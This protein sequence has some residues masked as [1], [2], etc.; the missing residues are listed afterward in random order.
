MNTKKLILLFIVLFVFCVAGWYI[1]GCPGA[2]KCPF[3]RFMEEDLPQPRSVDLSFIGPFDDKKEWNNIISKFNAYKRRPENG[4]LDVQISYER[5]CNP[6]CTVQDYDEVIK[7]RQF[8]GNGPNIF[9]VFHTWIPK[10][11]SEITSIPAGMMNVRQFESVFAKVAADDLIKDGKIYA[12][13]L[14]IDTLALFYN[15]DKFINE[16]YFSYPKNWDEFRNYVEKLTKLNKDGSIRVAGAAVGGGSNVARGQDLLML[17]VM[18]NNM[19]YDYDNPI[20]NLASFNNSKSE[21]AV[22][23]YTDFANPK[24]RFYTWSDDQIYSIDA[25][26]QRKAAMMINYSYGIE[27]IKT[28]TGDTLNFKIAPIPQLNS[29]IK[30]NYASYWVS[31]VPQYAACS[32]GTNIECQNLAWEFLDF[33]AKKENV[34]LYLNVKNKPAANINI[35]EKQFLD[36]DN[37]RSQFAGQILFAKSWGNVDNAQSDKYLDEMIDSIIAT[38]EE[39]KKTIKEAMGAIRSEVKGL[40]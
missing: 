14:Y 7:E 21:S 8:K 29:E 40:N 20:S 34:E 6:I 10:Y 18:Q 24:K 39:K 27:N 28:K 1:I 30:V 13:P 19:S 15:E 11:K 32:W 36:Y 26:T 23:F 33:V 3:V 5:V 22:R 35:A 31:V 16:R 9:M 12:L 37:T 4:F 25:F 2:S 17:L 38:D